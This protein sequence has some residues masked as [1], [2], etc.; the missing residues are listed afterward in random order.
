MVVFDSPVD[1]KG[2]PQDSRLIDESQLEIVKAQVV[3]YAFAKTEK[4]KETEA[5][6]PLQRTGGPRDSRPPKRHGE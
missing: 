5:E 4:T 6:K 2:V 3:P 1:K